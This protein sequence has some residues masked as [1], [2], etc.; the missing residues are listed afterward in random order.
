MTQKNIGCIAEVPIGYSLF[1][2][3][4]VDSFLNWLQK[5]SLI[6]YGILFQIFFLLFLERSQS[7][8]KVDE[9]SIKFI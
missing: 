1:N 7:F 6:F 4:N 2:W 9:W 3:N 5:D 8:G